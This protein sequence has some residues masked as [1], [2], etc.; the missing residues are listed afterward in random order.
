MVS[1]LLNIS[2]LIFKRKKI[3]ILLWIFLLILS[4][5]ILVFNK[6]DNS[7]TELKGVENSEAYKVKVILEKDFN[8][9][10]GNSS[11]IVVNSNID[12][13]TLKNDIKN[14][15]PEISRIF[16]VPS[17]VKHKNQLI[18]IEFSP[19]YTPIKMQG[20]GEISIIKL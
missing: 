11:A 20:L 15:F 3:I 8:L 19:K 7:E 18:Y 1:F 10:L 12:I 5:L 2:D 4:I 16:S 17:Q 14:K 6:N 9:K 13:N